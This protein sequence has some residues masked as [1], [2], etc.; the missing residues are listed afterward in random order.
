MDDPFSALAEA[1]TPNP[2]KT[3]RK[4]VETR[5][6]RAADR[7][8]AQQAE[9]DMEDE[10][11]LLVLYRRYKREQVTALLNGPF[12]PQ[13]AALVTIMRRM[14]L[15]EAG[16]LIRHIQDATWIK[17]L[18]PN[19]RFILLGMVGRAITK[20][21]EKNGLPPFDDGVWGENPK[22]FEKI[23]NIIGVR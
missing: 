12:G 7:S 10:G 4:A 13:V 11:K 19:D 22:A 9:K 16:E 20:L 23:R 3:R 2:V 21:R 14:D 17:L 8:R 5:R 6:T 15:T 1:L 18:S